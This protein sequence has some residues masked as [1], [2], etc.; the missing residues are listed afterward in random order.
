MEGR[1]RKTISRIFE[2]K[3]EEG[4]RE[5]ERRMLH[6]V[7]TFE[8]VLVSCGGGTPCFFDNIDFMNQ[9]GQTVYLK[10]SADELAGRLA[11]C[12]TKRPVLKGRTGETLR[13]FVAE[14]LK[15]RVPFYEQASVVFDAEHMTTEEDIRK[16]TETLIETLE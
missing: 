16:I 4:F 8:D 9:A 7:A 15:Q 11:C 3:G 5:L 2:E 10:V 12:K 6:E 13:R 14:S 1:F